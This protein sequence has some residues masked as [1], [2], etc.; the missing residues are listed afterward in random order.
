MLTE[1]LP[2]ARTMTDTSR[3]SVRSELERTI[4]KDQHRG[5]FSGRLRRPSGLVIGIALG[6]AVAAGGVAAAATTGGWFNSSGVPIAKPPPMQPEQLPPG[7]YD[8][9]PLNV[10]SGPQESVADCP[11][12]PQWS[13]PLP[14]GATV[15]VMLQP[16]G[17]AGAV[18]NGRSISVASYCAYT[19]T[20]P[21]QSSTTITAGG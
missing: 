10:P 2:S 14:A 11:Q 6:G 4:E 21:G 20:L 7:N 17:P 12:N 15:T 5:H 13:P 3:S 19:V 8:G 9:H 16:N 18:V 1:Q